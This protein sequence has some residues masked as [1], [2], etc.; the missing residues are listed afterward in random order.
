MKR[1]GEDGHTTRVQPTEELDDGEEEVQQ[2]GDEDIALRMVMVVMMMVAMPVA[3]AVTMSVGVLPRAPLSV[4][5]LLV[6]MMLIVVGY[7]RACSLSYL[8]GSNRTS[9]T[10]IQTIHLIPP[11]GRMHWSRGSHPKALPHPPGEALLRDE[12]TTYGRSPKKP[13][14]GRL[15]DLR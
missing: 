5:M 6:L 4:E 8:L 15:D 11:L 12:K 13:T 14:V 1:V 2:E 3:M 9:S 7:H 10:K